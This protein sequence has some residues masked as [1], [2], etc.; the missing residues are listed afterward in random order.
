MEC[1]LNT[2]VVRFPGH[3]A[4]RGVHLNSA[5]EEQAINQKPET[6]VTVKLLALV[7]DK[8]MTDPE[9]GFKKFIQCLEYVDSLYF[10]NI[11][12]KLGQCTIVNVFE[13]VHACAVNIL[14]LL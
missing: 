10:E 6:D 14:N 8:M 11:I 5:I 3:L 12:G 9:E 4:A 1:L 13:C 2:S 7:K